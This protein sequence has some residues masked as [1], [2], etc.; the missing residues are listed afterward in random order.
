MKGLR[1]EVGLNQCSL[2]NVLTVQYKYSRH[3]YNLGLTSAV[4]GKKIDAQ[5]QQKIQRY[6]IAAN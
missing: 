5:N 3:V 2:G 1:L 6:Y 4:T